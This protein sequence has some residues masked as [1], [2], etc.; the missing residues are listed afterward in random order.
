MRIRLD[1][2]YSLI[3]LVYVGTIHWL[4]SVP[5]LFASESDP[6]KLVMNL[7]HAPLF[8]G[9]AFCMVKSLSRVGGGWWERYALAF[10]VTAACAALDEWHQTFVPGRQ[11][12]IVDFL[13]D[14]AG[15]GGLLLILRLVAVRKERRHAGDGT[16]TDRPAMSKPPA[17]T[18]FP[19][20]GHVALPIRLVAG[21]NTRTSST[22]GRR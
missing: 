21:S 16:R 12:S 4:S 1:P 11:A 10:T 13:L 20:T 18:N 14:L 8:A 6:L 22:G 17:A 15:I 9:L 3:T 7:G 2:R 19:T 5:D